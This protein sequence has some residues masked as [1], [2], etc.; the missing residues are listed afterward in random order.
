MN[1]AGLFTHHKG[2]DRRDF[3]GFF[4]LFWG[5]FVVFFPCFPLF[6]PWS[7][8]SE[9]IWSK[10]AHLT[11]VS[12][13]GVELPCPVVPGEVDGLVAAAVNWAAA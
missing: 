4:W 9:R 1:R 2:K 7:W 12:R 11:L 8:M 13:L 6:G 3:V 5:F 10:R